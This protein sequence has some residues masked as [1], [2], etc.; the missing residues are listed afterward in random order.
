MQ[1][2]QTAQSDRHEEVTHPL[3]GNFRQQ[4]KPARMADN[5]QG[6]ADGE[7]RQDDGDV[8]KH[9]I[10]GVSQPGAGDAAPVIHRAVILRIGPG[11]VIGIVAEQG[12]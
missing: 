8:T 11:R 2:R 10:Q 7:H 1:R 3:R 4:V 12:R 6:A 9:K 5:K